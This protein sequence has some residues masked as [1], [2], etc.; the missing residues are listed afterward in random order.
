[1]HDMRAHPWY[2]SPYPI[3]KLFIRYDPD[4]WYLE[5]CTTELNQILNLNRILIC[6]F[7][8]VGSSLDLK[9]IDRVV[10][11]NWVSR[12]CMSGRVLLNPIFP[13]IFFDAVKDDG[14]LLDCTLAARP[15][16]CHHRNMGKMMVMSRVLRGNWWQ[17]LIVGDLFADSVRSDL[18]V[19]MRSRILSMRTGS[20]GDLGV[21]EGCLQLSKLCE[22]ER[23]CRRLSK[24]SYEVEGGVGSC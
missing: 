5:P 11:E 14:M 3:R 10:F 2:L 8:E 20:W 4:I 18:I 21:V 22:G 15:S 23:G 17:D 16:G 19:M 24:L 1:M 13:T 9:S 12:C 7:D 6:G